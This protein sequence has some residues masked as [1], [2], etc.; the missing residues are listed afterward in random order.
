MVPEGRLVDHALAELRAHPVYLKICGPLAAAT[1]PDDQADFAPII[2]PLL[3][4]RDGL[5]LDGHEHLALAR[6]QGRKNLPCLEYDL[7]EEDALT[8]MLRKHRRT[9]RLNDFCRIVMAL[10]LEP[11]WRDRARERQCKGGKEKLSSNLTEAKPIDVRAEVA[12]AAGVGAGNVTKVKQL[13]KSVIPKVYDAL[14]RGEVTIH[15]AWQWRVLPPN[16][17]NAELNKFINGKN[18]RQSMDGTIECLLSNHED[19]RDNG[20]SIE[21]FADRLAHAAPGVLG[22]VKLRVTDIPGPAVVVTRDLYD[23]LMGEKL[24]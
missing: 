13:L 17:Q 8:F 24:Q 19:H 21:H 12:R 23:Q 11:Y 4:T 5:I 1:I 14:R 16:R 10:T 18:A 6:H 22:N 2:E 3:V 7:N 20:L 15:R 9:H